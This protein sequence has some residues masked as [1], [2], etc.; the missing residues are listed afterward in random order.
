MPKKKRVKNHKA[1]G[2]KPNLVTVDKRLGYCHNKSHPGYLNKKIMD[3]HECIKKGCR[4]FEKYEKHKYWIHKYIDKHKKE[5]E[6]VYKHWKQFIDSNEEIKDEKL[7]ITF[8]SFSYFTNWVKQI[9]TE[10]LEYPRGEDGKVDFSALEE[11]I[12]DYLNKDKAKERNRRQAVML[13]KVFTKLDNKARTTMT[14]GLVIALTKNG[15]LGEHK[16][17]QEVIS[18]FNK[19]IIALDNN[20]ENALDFTS[21]SL[22]NNNTYAKL[23]INMCIEMFSYIDREVTRDT[24]VSSIDFLTKMNSIDISAEIQ[25]QENDE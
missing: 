7:K 6:Q 10:R 21:E 5:L 18:I 25:T 23:L 9:Y 3:E 22:Y 19:K 17:A 12:P 15:V 4:Y 13:S 11:I 2:T 8:I 16:I 14:I 1:I 24:L 20:C